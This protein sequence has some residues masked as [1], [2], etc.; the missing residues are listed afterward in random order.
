M[1]QQ[2]GR[3]LAYVRAEREKYPLRVQRS[4]DGRLADVVNGL[5]RRF[6]TNSVLPS[7]TVLN[8]T[9]VKVAENKRL[10]S[11][12]APS[13]RSLLREDSAHYLAFRI[14]LHENVYFYRK[15]LMPVCCAPWRSGCRQRLKLSLRF[16]RR[17]RVKLRLS[18]RLCVSFYAL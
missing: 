1:R 13:K 15:H 17:S 14:T 5:E 8:G 18:S 12:Q 3:R 10:S 6:F 4:D 9:A 16:P 7:P 2:Y 11:V